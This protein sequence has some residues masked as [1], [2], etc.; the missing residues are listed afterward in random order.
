MPRRSKAAI[1]ADRRY[2]NAVDWLL[3]SR[4]TGDPAIQAAF[5]LLVDG[6]ITEDEADQGVTVDDRRLVD[7]WCDVSPG[8]A[9]SPRSRD[10]A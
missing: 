9:A 5:W 3:N 6:Q 10:A 2:D 4:H 8:H 1:E 7:L